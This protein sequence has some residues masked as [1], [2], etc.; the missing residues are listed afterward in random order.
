MTLEDLRDRYFFY[1]KHLPLCVLEKFSSTLQKYEGLRKENILINRRIQF[2]Q[3]SKQS[4]LMNNLILSDDELFEYIMK[5]KE[6]LPYSSL[7]NE[8]GYLYRL[9]FSHQDE[10]IDSLLEHEGK[11][12]FNY[13][14]M[15][16]IPS[17][18]G[19]FSSNE[20]NN[21]AY[22]FYLKIFER[23]I[24][25]NTISNILFPFFD[26]SAMFRFY[27]YI[28]TP[29]FE[30]FEYSTSLANFQASIF[31]ETLARDLVSKIKAAISLIPFHQ[32]MLLKKIGQKYKDVNAS[33]FLII[34]I[35]NI[36]YS[37]LNGIGLSDRT[38][39]FAMVFTSI[40]NNPEL[41]NV[42][43]KT[44]LNLDENNSENHSLFSLYQVP[45]LYKPFVQGYLITYLSLQ[46]VIILSKILLAKVSLP[47]NQNIVIKENKNRF[48]IFEM[49]YY[50]R[51]QRSSDFE[52]S[53]EDKS[54]LIMQ[55]SDAILY[56]DKNADIALFPIKYDPLFDRKSRKIMNIAHENNEDPLDVFH[57][58]TTKTFNKF[59]DEC[60]EKPDSGKE[61]PLDYFLMKCVFTQRRSAMAIESLILYRTI[62]EDLKKWN[63]ICKKYDD[64][65]Y[66]GH[67]YNVATN[68]T[69]KYIDF[70]T[71]LAAAKYIIILPHHKQILFL[72]MVESHIKCILK[73]FPRAQEQMSGIF[74]FYIAT[75]SPLVTNMK[76]LFT[77]NENY[78]YFLKA[79]AKIADLDPYNVHLIYHTIFEAINELYLIAKIELIERKE[80][81]KDSTID[82]NLDTFL[83]VSRCYDFLWYYFLL[84]LFVIKN[85]LFLKNLT[86][87]EKHLLNIFKKNMDNLIESDIN[88]SDTFKKYKKKIST[89]K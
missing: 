74:K 18:F 35:Q 82:L 38:H 63:S 68:C 11:N 27:E 61:L 49:K 59:S 43:N 5:P 54:V 88:I 48:T 30:R 40:F 23:K 10:F 14:V 65:I 57:K 8:G 83:V 29:F 37:W 12:I 46:D 9:F 85:K 6:I 44:I 81:I 62:L 52:L 79:T 24:A 15:I 45:D 64:V 17:L 2:F 22:E 32:L 77:R 66:S 56:T 47:K 20:H 80:K 84:S 36:A 73:K 69:R 71:A 16:L 21:F 78:I 86:K 31:C 58:I 34:R 55:N 25:I 41:I 87:K 28:L 42:V 51:S 89:S 76:S 60:N 53:A 26:S 3:V 72:V 7:F 39:D 70:E 33:L 19:Y 4:D 1:Q 50:F 75:K 13:A 67:A